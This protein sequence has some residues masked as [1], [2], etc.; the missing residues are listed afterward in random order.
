[1]NHEA[2]S[3]LQGKGGSKHKAQ[4][5][6]ESVLSSARYFG[7]CSFLHRNVSL[8]LAV[9]RIKRKA[10]C[11]ETRITVYVSGIIYQVYFS[12]RRDQPIGMYN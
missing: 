11:L 4:Y 5:F 2:S 1:M 3:T 6:G 7:N 8:S 12:S 9:K 10:Q